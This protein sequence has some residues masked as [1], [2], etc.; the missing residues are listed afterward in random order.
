M[1]SQKFASGEHDWFFT[2]LRTSCRHNI[3]VL[4]SILNLITFQAW[5]AYCYQFSISL[6]SYI[7]SLSMRFHMD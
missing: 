3:V 5:K 6:L 2:A 1:T 4:H 7:P